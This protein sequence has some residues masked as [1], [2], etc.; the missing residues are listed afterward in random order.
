MTPERINN[1]THNEVQWWIKTL[2]NQIDA[3]N[4][5]IKGNK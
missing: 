5:A 2:N 1:M 4:K 3:E